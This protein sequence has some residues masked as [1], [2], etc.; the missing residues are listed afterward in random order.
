MLKNILNLEGAKKLTKNEQKAINGGIV[1]ICCL[2][3]NPRTRYCSEWD[4]ACLG[5]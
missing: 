2:V 5:S 3:W 1:P 4:Q